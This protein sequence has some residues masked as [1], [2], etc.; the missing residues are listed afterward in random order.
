[1]IA[2]WRPIGFEPIAESSPYRQN[3]GM[4]DTSE[5]EW[6]KA[7]R[8]ENRR[9]GNI[10]KGLYLAS[11]ALLA[12]FWVGVSLERVLQIKI[13]GYLFAV[14]STGAF[15]LAKRSSKGSVMRTAAI[16]TGV[17]LA[18]FAVLFVFGRGP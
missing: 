5:P 12:I 1:M 14:L 4:T 18:I 3:E 15:W 9:F 7:Q 16:T 11:P 10:W 6:A 13:A 17:M 2:V 8:E